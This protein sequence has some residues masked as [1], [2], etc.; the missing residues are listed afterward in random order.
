MLAVIGTQNEKKVTL[1]RRASPH[2]LGFGIVALIGVSRPRETGPHWLREIDTETD[3]KN[4][5]RLPK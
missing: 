5:K 4:T 1:T 3:K 2:L